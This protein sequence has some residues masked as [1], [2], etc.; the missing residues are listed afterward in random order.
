[1]SISSR[2]EHHAE[3]AADWSLSPKWPPRCNDPKDKSTKC[4][5]SAEE[6]MLP[7]CGAEK[8]LE[9]P[10]DYKEIQPVH[11]KEKQLN[12]HWNFH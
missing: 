7:N 6:L 8:T 10:L 4:E 11:P 1:M 2:W 5:L 3:A 12:I 9:S